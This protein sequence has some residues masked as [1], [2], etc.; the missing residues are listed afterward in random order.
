M[1]QIIIILS[2]ITILFIISCNSQNRS[3]EIQGTWSVT[4]FEAA[5]PNANEILVQNA[6]ILALATTYE[7]NTDHTFVMMIADNEIDEMARKEEGTWELDNNKH[8]KLKIEKLAFMVNGKWKNIEDNQYHKIT[9]TEVYK[10][11]KIK[12]NKILWTRNEG[13]GTISYTL[14]KKIDY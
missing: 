5:I 7:I 10:I 12:K 3:K 9:R 11:K 8:I 13:K 6:T 14:E 4:D 2:S 1:K